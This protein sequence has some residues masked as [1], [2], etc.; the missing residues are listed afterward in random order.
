M[1]LHYARLG[2]PM[3]NNSDCRRFSQIYICR[4]LDIN[5]NLNANYVPVTFLGKAIYD[6]GLKRPSKGKTSNLVHLLS[7]RIIWNLKCSDH[8]GSDYLIDFV[9]SFKWF[10]K[11]YYI[12]VCKLIY[13]QMVK[14]L[15]SSLREGS[16]KKLR[17]FEHMSKLQEGRVF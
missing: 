7:L 3:R 12:N 16:K 5:P 1:Y 8:I 15:A 2:V 11:N 6:I 9:F 4:Q 17:K 14:L 13:C 10:H